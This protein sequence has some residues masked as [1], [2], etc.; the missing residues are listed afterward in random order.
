MNITITDCQSNISKLQI[1]LDNLLKTIP[2][3]TCDIIK[4]HK[5]LTTVDT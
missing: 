4:Y 1:D 2:P 3:K 5:F